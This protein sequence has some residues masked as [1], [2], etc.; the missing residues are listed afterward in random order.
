MLRVARQ[1]RERKEIAERESRAEER[2]DERREL[3]KIFEAGKHLSTLSATALV[4]IFAAQRLE[5]VDVDV[6]LGMTVFGISL[7]EA[8]FCVNIGTIVAR[9]GPKGRDQVVEI[10]RLQ[11][12]GAS[13]FFTIG[14]LFVVVV[15]SL[16]AQVNGG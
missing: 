16:L 13:L 15:P 4:L 9:V 12:G 7:I 11:L 10:A 1:E 14:V 3:D 2:E 5:S 8:L 6:L